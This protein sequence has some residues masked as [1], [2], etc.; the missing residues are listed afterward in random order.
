MVIT[1]N[2]AKVSNPRSPLEPGFTVL[3]PLP[4]TTL[5]FGLEN[6]LAHYSS[7]GLD[8]SVDPSKLNYILKCPHWF[9]HER[10]KLS[11]EECFDRISKS[12]GVTPEDLR[13][14]FSKLAATLSYDQGLI[15]LIRDLKNAAQGDLKVCLATNFTEGEWKIVGPPVR[16]WA[17]FDN[18]F[19]TFTMGLRKP[20]ADVYFQIP[21]IV[22]TDPG[23]ALYIDDKTENL[24][25]AQ[26]FGI[27]GIHCNESKN[28]IR[29]LKNLFGDPVARGR[30]WMHEHAKEM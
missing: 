27:R 3:K 5:I 21:R 16:S 29:Q 19:N 20:D 7:K 8:L 13:K 28:V 12:F 10:G 6:V 30:A 22:N 24:A 23:R 25:I 9:E 26:K 15:D 2:G 18:V 4:Y 11:R 1:L 17:I 14:T